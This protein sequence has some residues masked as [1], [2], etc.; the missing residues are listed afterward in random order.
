MEY[1]KKL[2]KNDLMIERKV[3]NTQKM[4]MKKKKENFKYLNLL[5]K[6]HKIPEKVGQV[7][8]N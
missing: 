7:I 8:K 2:R 3:I 6:N 1:K 4:K 5:F